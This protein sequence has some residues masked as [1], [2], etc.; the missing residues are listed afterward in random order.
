M[1][2]NGTSDSSCD[3]VVGEEA[4]GVLRIDTMIRLWPVAFEN[5]TD[6]FNLGD[7]ESIGSVGSSVSEDTSLVR[8]CK[9]KSDDDQKAARMED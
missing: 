1:S 5:I 7:S 2:S 8:T 9:R 4:R 3:V 6:L